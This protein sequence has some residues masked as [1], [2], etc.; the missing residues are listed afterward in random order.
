VTAQASKR[1]LVDANGSPFPILGRALW[2][3]CSLPASDYQLLLNDTAARGYNVVEFCAPDRDPRANKAPFAGDG[4]A[5]F[6]RRLDGSA[7]AGAF[8]YT[9]IRAQ[10]PDFSTPNP[11]FWDHVDGVIDYM[12]SKRMLGFMFPAYLGASTTDQGWANEM[13]ANGPGRMQ[14]YGS[15]IANR[16]KSRNN[17]V[18]MLGGDRGT[19]PDFLTNAEIGVE[20]ALIDGLRSAPRQHTPQFSAEWSSESVATDQTTFGATMTLNGAYS[21][22][23]DVATQGRRAYAHSPNL[24]AYLLEEPYDEEGPDGNNVNPHATQPTRQFQWRGWLSTIGGYISGNGYVWPMNPGWRSHLDTQGARDM[25]RLNA[26]ILSIKW[27]EL[28]PS[29]LGGMKT[30]VLSHASK[31]SDSDYVAA[32]ATPAGDLLI[33]YIPPAHFG[34]VTI[35]MTAMSRPARARWFDPTASTYVSIGR[36]ANAGARTFMPAGANSRGERDWVLVIEAD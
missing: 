6:L 23:G 20:H 27:Y 29:G 36:I 18:W 1:C 2:F 25:T 28:V 4:A 8:A 21:F 13:V 9:D 30:L 15:W 33:A 11:A 12:A 34:G 10:A 26:F 19:S 24:P 35:D 17:L 16:Y 22:N 5:P 7:Y 32:A 3:V 14:A 31:P